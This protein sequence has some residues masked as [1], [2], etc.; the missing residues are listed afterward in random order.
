MPSA[1]TP[2]SRAMPGNVPAPEL[3]RRPSHR[4]YVGRITAA[5]ALSTCC[6]RR[7]TRAR[8]PGNP[9]PAHK[10]NSLSRKINETPARHRTFWPIA[11]EIALLASIV[12]PGVAGPL[13]LRDCRAAAGTARYQAPGLIH[14]RRAIDTP[15][16]PQ[17][18]A[19]LA[20][21]RQRAKRLA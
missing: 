5:L 20:D 8:V 16:I 3:L 7:Q 4:N 10:L 14:L 11:Y 1:T 2:E 21:R 6:N 12:P 17:R 18:V 15:D 13:M 19:N 9:C